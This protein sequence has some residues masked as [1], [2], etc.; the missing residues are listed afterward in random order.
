MCAA[1]IA[2]RVEEVVM[3]PLDLGAK[4]QCE[5]GGNIA[6]AAGGQCD[7][8]RTNIT[9]CSRVRGGAGRWDGA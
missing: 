5:I 8:V 2:E 7:S 1:D 4:G 9:L 6:T 3:M